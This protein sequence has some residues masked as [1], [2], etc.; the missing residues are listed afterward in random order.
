MSESR[1]CQ[2]ASLGEEWERNNWLI[3]LE[4]A[5]AIPFSLSLKSQFILFLSLQ[6][7]QWREGGRCGRRKEQ[8][9]H[10]HFPACEGVWTVL[11]SK[12][13]VEVYLPLP[14][15]WLLIPSCY[16]CTPSCI[17]AFKNSAWLKRIEA[18]TH[19]HTSTHKEFAKIF[20]DPPPWEFMMTYK[21]KKFLYT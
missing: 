20:S 13:S 10:G 11:W 21:R 17:Q 4:L 2:C 6:G 12:I 5:R 15:Q 8:V 18:Q 1:S 16:L 7:Q 9:R 14:L 19:T 3:S